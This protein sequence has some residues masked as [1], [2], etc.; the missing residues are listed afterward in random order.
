MEQTEAVCCGS[1]WLPGKIFLPY[2]EPQANTLCSGFWK[3]GLHRLLADWW[4]RADTKGDADSQ[5]QI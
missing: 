4:M 5:H 3:E 1:S 2:S